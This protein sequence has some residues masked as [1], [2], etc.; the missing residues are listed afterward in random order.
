MVWSFRKVLEDG[1]GSGKRAGVVPQ[2]MAMA[3]GG[4]E[5]KWNTAQDFAGDGWEAG[6]GG[7]YGG[8]FGRGGPGGS[9]PSSKLPTLSVRGSKT[10]GGR[11]SSIVARGRG[12]GFGGMGGMRGGFPGMRGGLGSGSTMD[13]GGGF[14]GFDGGF[15][16]G[17]GVVS[18][19]ATKTGRKPIGPYMPTGGSTRARPRTRRRWAPS[20]SAL[21]T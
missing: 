10:V 14:G 7:G 4:M 16:G 8:S 15:G 3:Q 20:W 2:L 6:W 19:Y 17:R 11:W 21:S 12:M 9:V 1:Q 18:S 13:Y 5:E